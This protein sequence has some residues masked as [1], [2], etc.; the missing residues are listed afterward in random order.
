MPVKSLSGEQYYLVEVIAFVLKHMKQH[1]K[2]KL[3][4]VAPL[5]STADIH[6]VITVPAI[7]KQDGKQMMREAAYRVR[8]LASHGQ[9]QFS[10]PLRCNHNQQV[11]SCSVFTGVYLYLYIS[12]SVSISIICI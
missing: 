8:D 4:I 2:D 10:T 3:R 1:L 12:V 5:L 7:W 9:I 11:H 6:W